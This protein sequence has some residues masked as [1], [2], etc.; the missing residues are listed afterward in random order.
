ME[1]KRKKHRKNRFFLFT[2]SLFYSSGKE[3]SRKGEALLFLTR[4]IEIFQTL[5]SILSDFL[6]ISLFCWNS[7]II[8]DCINFFTKK[9]LM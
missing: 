3:K 9:K 7:G 5:S 6:V 4:R 8:M 2:R 1:E